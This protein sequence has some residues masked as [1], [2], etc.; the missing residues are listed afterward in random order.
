YVK[1]YE[2]QSERT[3][4]DLYQVEL[5][6]EL[7]VDLLEQ[8]LRKIERRERRQVEHLTLVVLPTAGMGENLEPVDNGGLRNL[9]L[10]PTVLEQS[11]QQELAVYGFSLEVVDTISPDLMGMFVQLLQKDELSGRSEPEAAWF[12]G[13]LS[14][15]LIVAIRPGEVSE[16]R[17]VSLRKSFWRSRAELVFIDTK[18]DMITHLPT[19]TA[20]VISSDYVA[21]LEKL[22][23]N[24]TE[25]VQQA[26]L[27]RLLRD[28]IVPQESEE[29][30]VLQF[31]GFR[32]PADFVLFKERL[33]S[34]R[35][36]KEVSLQALAAGSIELGVRILIS[37]PLLIKWFNG[38]SS[39]D[40]P[41]TFTV[42]PLDE[43]PE[44]YLIRVN[45]DPAAGS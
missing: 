27:D 1:S 43:T 36:V 22:T 10:E 5:R 13:L 17:I 40:L 37:P 16:E 19:V 23:Q 45:Y 38:F 2:I 24:L 4:G 30:M 12:Q 25:G 42:Y 41:F 8:E 44:H 20:K 3:L 32:R 33:Q 7:Q 26:C 15:D 11:L 28:Y 14:G 18:N 9:A 39:D 35:T 6:V 21:G 31:E 29:L 34:L